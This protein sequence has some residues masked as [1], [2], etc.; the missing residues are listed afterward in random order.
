MIGGVLGNL[1]LAVM[2]PEISAVATV[3]QVSWLLAFV[4]A[5]TTV[6]WQQQQPLAVDSSATFLAEEPSWRPF[7]SLLMLAAECSSKYCYTILMT[8]LHISNNTPNLLPLSSLELN[9]GPA[10]KSESSSASFKA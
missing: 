5:T 7:S 2:G 8:L 6:L 3:A 4:A 10:C 1:E 9:K